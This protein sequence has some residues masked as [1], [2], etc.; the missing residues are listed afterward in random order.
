M[1][2]VVTFVSILVNYGIQEGFFVKWMRAWGLAFVVALPVVMV[3]M[4]TIRKF[5]S[6]YVE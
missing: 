3:V 5:V 1:T 2:L 4:P 6:K